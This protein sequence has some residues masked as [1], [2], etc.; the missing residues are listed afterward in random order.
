MAGPLA[1]VGVVELAG[2]GAAPFCGMVLADLG[3]E[4]VR[5]DRADSVV[6]G[7]AS[8]AR[9]DVLGRGKLSM[10]VNLKDR[11]GAEA[12]LRLVERSDALIEGFRPGVTERLGLG[13]ADCLA[14]RPSLVYGRM[15]G[16]GQ[17]GPFAPMAGHDID[18]IALSGALH[19]IGP[20]ERP[21]LPLNLVGDYGGGGMLL[22]VGVL[23]ALLHARETGAGQAVDGAMVDGSALLTAQHHGL[24]AEGRWSS[25]ERESNWLDG[26]APFYSTYRTADGEHMAVGALEPQFYA[27]LLERLEIDPAELSPQMDR[28]GWPHMRE[29]FAARFGARTRDEWAA[30][31]EGSD[32][33][34]A[35]VLSMEE[36]PGHPHNRARGG[37][38]TIDGVTQ[39]APAPRFSATK[40]E[41]PTTPAM[42]GRDTDAVM[43]SLG[44]G[45]DEIG[46]LRETGAIA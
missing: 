10:G 15:T 16:W 6:G 24:A 30:R 23:A 4:V 37:F 29:V 32:A 44:Y 19:A 9:S 42:P 25:E 46:M 21:A 2:L 41:A 33:C 5:V 35:P 28:S 20:K 40:P 45:P 18:Y 17:E 1:G 34:V 36:A 26:A 38:T 8:S 14:R 11:R 3:A 7:D 43:G 31:F 22:A 39:P 13:P 27:M 12:V